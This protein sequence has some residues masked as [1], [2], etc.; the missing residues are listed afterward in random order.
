MDTAAVSDWP[1]LYMFWRAAHAL[2]ISFEGRISRIATAKTCYKIAARTAVGLLLRVSASGHPSTP[3]D[4]PFRDTPKI[5]WKIFKLTYDLNCL[6]PGPKNLK[7]WLLQQLAAL[8]WA[9]A[10]RP[11]RICFWSWSSDTTN[12]GSKGP[13]SYRPVTRKDWV[14]SWIPC[15]GRPRAALLAYSLTIGPS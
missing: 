10:F 9:L 11:R 12:Y 3:P 6:A 14:Q 7:S 4:S 5:S 13:F 8:L 1:S 15:S 2:G